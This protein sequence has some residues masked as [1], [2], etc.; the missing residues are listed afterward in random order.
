MSEWANLVH[1]LGMLARLERS[2]L[3]FLGSGRQSVA[4]HS[5][6]VACIALI[7]ARRCKEPVDEARLAWLC[8][9][10]DLPETRIGDHNYVN[11]KYL[12]VDMERLRADI[13]TASPLGKTLIA[14]IDEFEQGDTLEARLARDADQI[15]LLALL[16]EEADLGN[17]RAEGWIRTCIERVQT[18]AGRELAS[19]VL[20]T[21]A[22][23]WWFG[24]KHDPHWVTGKG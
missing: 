15:D 20:A 3:H 6:R 21:P 14:A 9:F 10:H 4:E 11:R 5:H 12:R 17:P 22:D 19:E 1:E 2:G 24:N 18:P 16:R 8:L 13:S 7:L 23:D